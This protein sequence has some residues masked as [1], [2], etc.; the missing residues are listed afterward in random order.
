M[1][2]GPNLPDHYET[3]DL[4][5]PIPSL[6]PQ[7]LKLA[8]HKALL[9]HHPDKAKSSSIDPTSPSPSLSNPTNGTN[10]QS[11]QQQTYTI[12]QITSAYKT[13]STPSLRKSYDLTLRQTRAEQKKGDAFHTGLE[14]IDL[15]DFEC[16]ECDGAD[17]GGGDIWF[18]G[19]RCGDEKGF[20][21]TEEDLEK[22]IET[23][24]VVVGC[25]GCSL[26]VKV[27]FAVDDDDNQEEEGNGVDGNVNAKANGGPL[28]PST[29]PQSPPP[30]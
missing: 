7:Q 19:C 2:K 26:W 9:K 27:L 30:G 16:E 17:A 1:A 10:A 5:F 29:S 6:T 15:E 23:G 20:I 8:Y 24:E 21:V 14:P 12:D 13:L 22:E 3:L 4:P 18:R 25:R 28:S 11:Q